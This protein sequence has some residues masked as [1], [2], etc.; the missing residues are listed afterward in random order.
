MRR[1]GLGS[2]LVGFGAVLAFIVGLQT[3]T[4]S[5]VWRSL[6]DALLQQV[7]YTP[8]SWL[9]A[10]AWRTLREFVDGLQGLFFV[11]LMVGG[12]ATIGA[13]VARAVAWARV[14]DGKADPLERLRSR[15]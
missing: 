11:G 4:G 15:Q 2:V 9:G 8:H 3:E 13:V 7:Y 10:V 12:V 5:Y 6:Q 1:R 14:R